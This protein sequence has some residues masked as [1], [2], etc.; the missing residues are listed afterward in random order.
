MKAGNIRLTQEC[1][2]QKYEAYDQITSIR[3][4]DTKKDEGI[5]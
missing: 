5:S 1:V 2:N 4:T 3:T